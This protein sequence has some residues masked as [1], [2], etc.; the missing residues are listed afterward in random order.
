MGARF[1]LADGGRDWRSCYGR[2]YRQ[3][4]T[5]EL[6][7]SFV[8]DCDVSPKTMKNLIATLPTMWNSAK[9]WGYVG[10]DP[11]DAL[12]LPESRK[13]EQRYFT[14]EEMCR[15]LEAA[16]EPY[17]TFYWLAAETGMRASELCALRWGISTANFSSS[18]SVTASGE[19]SSS[20]LNPS[21]GI[22]ASQS[23]PS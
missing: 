4:I 21:R 16:P 14:I 23:A 9:A 8:T 1:W 5:G 18:R 10:H 7:E 13:E 2:R 12:V 11:F 6:V 22:V 3:D 17:K 15:I 19:E 20:R